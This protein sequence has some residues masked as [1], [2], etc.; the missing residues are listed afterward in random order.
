MSQQDGK[1]LEY[2]NI[3]IKGD[4]PISWITMEK[5]SMGKI[6]K[7]TSKPSRKAR[8]DAKTMNAILKEA[9]S[10]VFKHGVIYTTATKQAQ[11]MNQPKEQIIF[12]NS[13][14]NFNHLHAV[15]TLVYNQR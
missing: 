15:K 13:S 8:L 7:N 11:K 2:G 3:T 14:R 4:F 12:K 1:I 9:K 5:P 6:H 10:L